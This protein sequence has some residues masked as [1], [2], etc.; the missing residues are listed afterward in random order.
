MENEKEIV[1][2]PLTMRQRILSSF[3]LIGLTLLC[4]FLA[5]GFC[6]SGLSCVALA[7]L[8][9][10]HLASL[11][12]GCLMQVIRKTG[13]S[14][15][16]WVDIYLQHILKKMLY[17]T[18]IC[19]VMLWLASL[20]NRDGFGFW[21]LFQSIN[22]ILLITINL[23]IGWVFANSQVGNKINA[24][25]FYPFLCWIFGTIILFIISFI[26]LVQFFVFMY[27][28][29]EGENLRRLNFNLVH[30]FFGILKNASTLGHKIKFGL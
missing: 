23:Q 29:V 26:P 21:M 20:A 5:G 25:P 15:W 22:I 19:L 2:T 18:G 12:F 3:Y 1:F 8:L 13:Y 7:V 16:Y 9:S 10:F 6:F 30:Y 11:V 4:A 14:Y 27:S 17:L 28:L 24:K